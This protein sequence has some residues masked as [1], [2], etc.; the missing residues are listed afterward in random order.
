M[1]KYARSAIALLLP[2]QIELPAN[3][4]TLNCPRRGRVIARLSQ[5]VLDGVSSNL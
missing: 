5:D 1:K 2:A 3:M 4:E